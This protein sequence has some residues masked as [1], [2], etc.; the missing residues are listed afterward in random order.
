VILFGHSFFL[1]QD[2]KQ[3]EKMKPYP[4]LSTLLAAALARREGHAAAL[5]DATFAEGPRAFAAALERLAP[6]AVVLMEDNFNFLTKM[7]TAVRRDSALE[8]C[9]PRGPTAAGWRSTA[10]TRPIIPASI[11][12]P[13]PTRSC[14]ARARTRWPRRFSA[15]RAGRGWRPFP[16]WSWRAPTAGRDRHRPGA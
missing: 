1:A 8:M 12:T 15:G 11:W 3:R 4:P 9:A 10:P 2:A 6:S 5:F 16:A 14:W 13:A 7:C